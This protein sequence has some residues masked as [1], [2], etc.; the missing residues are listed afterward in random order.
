[1]TERPRPNIMAD[2]RDYFHIFKIY[3]YKHL[4]SGRIM[5]PRL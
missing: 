3:L 5:Y 1:M 4:A 2:Y